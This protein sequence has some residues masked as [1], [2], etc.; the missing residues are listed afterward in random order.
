MF[1]YVCNCLVAIIGVLYHF[2][3]FLN[4]HIFQLI[5]YGVTTGNGLHAPNHV[6][7]DNNH[8]LD[9]LKLKPI[10]EEKSASDQS[11]ILKI[12]IPKDA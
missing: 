2:T 12:A 6:E 9:E 10:T 8:A 1:S 4:V 3:I 11:K 7:V 5:V